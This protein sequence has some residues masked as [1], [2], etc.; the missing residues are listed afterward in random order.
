MVCKPATP[1]SLRS[2][3]EELDQALRELRPLLRRVFVALAQTSMAYPDGCSA[4]VEDHWRN[5]S[6]WGGLFSTLELIENDVK[7]AQLEDPP[8]SY[9]VPWLSGA[10]DELGLPLGVPA[11]LA[12]YEARKAAKGR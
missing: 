8:Y 9:A 1:E 12:V 6:G 7:A 11:H 2:I 4:E 5:A 3:T 10:C